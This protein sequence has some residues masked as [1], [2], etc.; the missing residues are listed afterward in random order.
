MIIA[1]IDPGEKGA[2]AIVNQD[3]TLFSHK[4]FTSRLEMYD[5]IKDLKPGM[6]YLEKL[7]GIPP[8]AAATNF[9]LG[10]HFCCNQFTLEL[11]KIPYEEVAAKT[12]QKRV[13]NF[14][15][16]KKNRAS[17]KASIAFVSKKYPE[18]KL[19]QRTIKD[20]DESS[21]IADAI[22]IALYGRSIHLGL[23]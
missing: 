5:Y 6:V 19:P 2:V 20:I 11:L 1:G 22:C 9:N 21:G 14:N 8:S 15:G 10:C 23:N 13:L 12:W 3:G 16:S 17:K 7:W 4:Q 18:L